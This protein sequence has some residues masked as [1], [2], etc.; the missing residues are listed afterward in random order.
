MILKI[1]PSAR[2][3]NLDSGHYE[4]IFLIRTLG[5]YGWKELRDAGRSWIVDSNLSH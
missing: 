5:Y 4:E 3:I 2:G 1:N